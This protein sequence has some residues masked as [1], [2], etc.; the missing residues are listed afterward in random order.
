M[1]RADEGS[2]ALPI[3]P[4]YVERASRPEAEAD[5]RTRLPAKLRSIADS[6][7]VQ[8]AREA[9]GYVTHPAISRRHKVLGVAALLYLIAPFDAVADW[10]PGL[11]YV[12]DA[13]VLTALALVLV[14]ASM[15]LFERRD[16]RQPG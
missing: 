7:L 2:E 15:L 9:H 5:L 6:R 8:L 12:D 14:G 10:I 1:D 11:S 3:P 16:L 4:R 13:A